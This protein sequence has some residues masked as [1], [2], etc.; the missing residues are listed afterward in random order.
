MTLQQLLMQMTLHV[1]RLRDAI[2]EVEQSTV[3]HT[4]A[5]KEA[6]QPHRL[7][8]NLKKSEALL[9]LR[10]A[11]SAAKK[12]F[13]GTW[14]G[15]PLRRTV[16]YLGAHFQASLS[17]RLEVTKRI[18]AART[19]FSK[20]AAFFRNS[21]VPLGQKKSVFRS[22]VNDAFLSALEVRTLTASDIEKLESA[23]GLLLR[24]IFGKIG[25]GATRH[26]TQHRSVPISYLRLQCGVV[27][28]A[29][30]LRVRRLTGL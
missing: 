27:T 8:L 18:A 9:A 14:K 10:G 25:F 1:L 23:R 17:T 4:Q 12:A 5:L 11:Y 30:E 24:R 22:V 6:L 16:K 26:D 15:P 19:G 21:R 2:E 13:S 3:A 28:I 20:F 7:E 29:C